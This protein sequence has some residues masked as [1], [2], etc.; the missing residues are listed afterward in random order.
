MSIVFTDADYYAVLTPRWTVCHSAELMPSV[1]VKPA[2]MVPARC[3]LTLMQ[4]R[5]V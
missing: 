1:A 5:A 3:L 2:Q 4:G